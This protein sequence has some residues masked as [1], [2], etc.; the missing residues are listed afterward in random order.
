M[1]VPTYER[2]DHMRPFL[3]AY[4]RPSN[5]CRLSEQWAEEAVADMFAG[6]VDTAVIGKILNITEAEAVR[7]LHAAREKGRKRS[8]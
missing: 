1:I 8:E 2:Y 6:G 3:M 7:L 4:G 5:G